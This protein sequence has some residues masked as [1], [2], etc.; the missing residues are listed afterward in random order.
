[1]IT[2][3]PLRD[4]LK[5]NNITWYR[6]QKDLDF[7]NSTVER[8]KEGKELPTELPTIDRICKKYHIPVERVIKFVEDPE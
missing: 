8:F 3:E 7:E 5:E 6:F 4:Y 2:Y 1:M